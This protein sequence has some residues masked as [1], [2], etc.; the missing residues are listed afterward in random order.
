MDRT[1]PPFAAHLLDFIGASEAPRGY[2]T[3]YGNNQSKLPKRVTQMTIAEIQNAQPG[4][5]KRFGSSATGRYQFMHATLRGLIKE[6]GLDT[7]A[8]FDAD[9]QDRLGFH[10]LKRRGYDKFVTGRIGMIAFAKA[11]AQE[12][13]SLPVLEPTEGAHRNVSRGQSYYAGDGLNKSLVAPER[14]EAALRAQIPGAVATTKPTVPAS[15]KAKTALAAGGAAGAAAVAA[16]QGWGAVEWLMFGAVCLALAV[17]I[18]FAGRWW[19]RRNPPAM[20][21]QPAVLPEKAPEQASGSEPAENVEKKG[22]L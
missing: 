1:I 9:M 11:L 7:S 3:V 12:W 17:A 14:V 15:T 2:D 22:A 20:L 21:E 6:L 8:K 13:A 16:Q 18:F 10:L 19:G 5:S 4:W